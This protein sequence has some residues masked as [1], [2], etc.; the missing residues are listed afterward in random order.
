M[1]ITDRSLTDTALSGLQASL[2][3]V[4]ILQ[5]QLSSGKTISKPSDNPTGAVQAMQVRGD[6]LTQNQYSRNADDGLGWLGT[7]DSTLTGTMSQIQRVRQLTLTA[8]STGNNSTGNN[9]PAA[10]EVD[11]IRA[12]LIQAANTQYLGRPVFGGATTGQLAFNADGSYA[13]DTPVI[14]RTVGDNTKIQV[15][16]VGTSVFG[17]GTGQLFTVL[18]AISTDMRNNDSAALGK[19]LGALDTATGTIQATLSDVGARYNRIQGMQTAANTRADDLGSQLSDIEDVDLPK[20]ITELQM[21]QVAYQ[22]ALAATAKAIQ[23]SLVD[24]LK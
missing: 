13:G 20:T 10:V 22:S 3:R 9:E 24:F 16:A 1:R 11:N 7:I 15:N 14:N 8:M 5:Q 6:I 21:Q 17:T 18:S 2:S 4:A 12:S 23:P 19:D